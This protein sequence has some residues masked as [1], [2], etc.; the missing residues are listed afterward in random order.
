MTTNRP[1]NTPAEIA[2]QYVHIWNESDP[3]RRR[4]LIEQTF[5][6]DASYI[7]PLTQSTGHQALD[8]MISVAQAQFSG[9]SF[10]VSGKPDGHHEVL[11]FSWSL[12]KDDA[13]PVARGTDIAV[14]APDGRIERITGFLD[15]MPS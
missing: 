3:T 14:I 1:P 13:C 11:R 7:D 15:K 10:S 8:A 2:T 12:G 6:P 5:T 9:L 4:T